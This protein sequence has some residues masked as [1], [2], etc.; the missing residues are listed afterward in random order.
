MS[1][2]R[3]R[4]SNVSDIVINNAKE[5]NAKEYHAN[6]YNANEYNAK[7][8]RYT[9]KAAALSGEAKTKGHTRLH[10]RVI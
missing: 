5:F 6:E 7:I 3:R 10:D 4:R 2:T 9:A 1:N 8:Q